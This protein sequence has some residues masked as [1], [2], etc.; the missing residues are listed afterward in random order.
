MF[1]LE[2][3]P[4]VQLG[5]SAC[6]MTLA[7][8]DERRVTATKIKPGFWLDTN[9]RTYNVHMRAACKCRFVF[10][11]NLHELLGFKPSRVVILAI[12]RKPD[13]TLK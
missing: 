3:A 2:I 13:A 11:F 5:K 9:Q 1:L 6:R 8:Y 7:P 4:V 12:A 10:T